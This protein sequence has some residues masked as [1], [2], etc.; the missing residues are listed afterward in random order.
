MTTQ[1]QKDGSGILFK[2]ER[3]TQLN[4]PDYKGT[5]T[6][7]GEQFWLSAWIKQAQNGNK[8]MGLAITPKEQ[9]QQKPKLAVAG[10]TDMDD[11]I[12]F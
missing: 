6:V 9:E 8:F 3:K 5:I 4:Q 11:E 7:H 12:P 2:N 10:G 1:N